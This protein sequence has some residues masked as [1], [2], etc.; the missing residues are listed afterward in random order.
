MVVNHPQRPETV[1]EELSIVLIGD[2]NPKIFQP[3]WF[4]SQSLLRASEA[5]ASNIE[6]VHA[7]FTSFSTDWFVMQVARDRFTITVKSSAYKSHLRDLVLGTFHNLSHTPLTQM[8]INYSA[9]LR[10]INERDWHCFGHFLLPKNPWSGLLN[11][12]GMRSVSVEGKRPDEIPGLIVVT[13]DPVR[14]MNNEA[15]LRVN[16]HCER[17]LEDKSAGAMFFTEIIEKD[18]DMVIDRSKKLLD[19]LIKRFLDQSSFE[20]GC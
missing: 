11:T 19:D 15:I 12:P 7:D 16:D 14:N 9:R 20:D 10:F 17:S 6:L 4:V 2:F 8:G 18:Y 13:A 3:A 1:G 5:E